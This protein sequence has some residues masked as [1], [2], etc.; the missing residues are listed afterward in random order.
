MSVFAACRSL[1]P[2]AFDLVTHDLLERR[3]RRQREACVQQYCT[4]YDIGA[5]GVP[6]RRRPFRP[7]R[8]RMVAESRCLQVTLLLGGPAGQVVPT[9]RPVRCICRVHSMPNP[10]AHRAAAAW[11]LESRRRWHTHAVA[12]DPCDPV[13]ISAKNRLRLQ[14]VMMSAGGMFCVCAELRGSGKL[15]GDGGGNVEPR[16]AVTWMQ[17]RSILQATDAQARCSLRSVYMVHHTVH[18]GTY[19]DAESSRAATALSG[20]M[21]WS[22]LRLVCVATTQLWG[23]FFTMTQRTSMRLRHACCCY[24]MVVALQMLACPRSGCGRL[25]GSDLKARSVLQS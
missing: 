23:R 19:W 3:A 13:T 21:G 1:Q 18:E 22:W 5:L 7:I 14:P 6:V 17:G 4:G 25:A 15:A 2:R 8:L 20:F 11:L 12:H 16:A 10:C 24:G 9:V